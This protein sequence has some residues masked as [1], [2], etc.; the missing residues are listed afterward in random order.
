[1]NFV[2][3]AE[4]VLAQRSEL[5]LFPT[6]PGKV[7][8]IAVNSEGNDTSEAYLEI[9]DIEAPFHIWGINEDTKIAAGDNI[10]VICAASVYNYSSD[11]NWYLNNNLV[12]TGDNQIVEEY[13]TEYSYQK[14]ITWHGI[15]TIH[16]GTYECR[17]STVK[18]DTFSMETVHIQVHEPKKPEIESTNLKQDEIKLSL[19]E[20]FRMFC[21]IIA[22]P[23]PVISWYKNG[24]LIEN[25]TRISIS[26]DNQTLDIKYLKIEDDGEFKCVG[27]NRVGS[28]E[29][30][31]SLKI[32]NLPEVSLAWVI[33]IS[34]V[35][36]IL[37]ICT[38][39]LLIRF[40]RERRLRR[41]L[42]AA[43]LANFEEG[44][45]ESINP[46]LALDE[47]ADLLP[48]DKKYEFPREK[49]KLGK[50]LGA[51]AFGVVVK[52]LAHGILPYE[53]ETTVAVKMV[54]QTADNEV[55]RALV[56]ELK[57]MVHLGQ[58]LNVVN[59]LGA[60]TKNIAKREVM[61]IVE[62][63]R[64]GNVQNF[65][66]KHR[67]HY[68]DQINP[69]TDTIDPSILT[70]EQRYSNDSGYEY[71]SQGL[72]Y[73]KLSFSN[74][75]LN[76]S[77]RVPSHLNTGGGYIRQSDYFSGGMDSANT[78][79][80]LIRPVSGPGLTGEDNLMLSN[81]SVQPAWRSNYK[82]DYKGP[83]RVVTTT[84][85]V[86][87]SFQV[88]RGME[89]LA[90]RKV[91]HGDLAA[92]NILLCDDNVVKICD[93]G[94][95][96]SMYKSDNYK[97]KGEAPLPFKWLAIESIGD[98]VFSTYSDVW[99][100]GIVMW[101]LFSLGKVPYPGMDADQSLYMK[102]KDGYRMGKPE[103]ATQEIYDVMLHCWNANPE[104]R[105][106]FN[107]LEKRLGK[108]LESG[109]A[110]HYI[111]LNEPYLQINTDSF[112][113]GQ[114][115][116]LSFMGPPEGV[117]PSI[118]NYVNSSMK[119]SANAVPD[120][121]QVDSKSGSATYNTRDSGDKFETKTPVSPTIRNNLNHAS[122][123]SRSSKKPIP[124]EMPMLP[125][126]GTHRHSDSDV[127]SPD[128]KT[129]GK[130]FSGVSGS[131]ND[132]KGPDNYVNMPST[133]INMKDVYNNKD[134]VSNPGYVTFGKINETRT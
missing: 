46:E 47:Q 14:K 4:T 44:N 127:E 125:A 67:E 39:Y 10:T 89:Y 117:A 26:S 102:L 36:I 82:M 56:T 120:Y 7:E 9:T 20:P 80:A 41:E 2:T 15:K 122:P 60:V 115:D 79:V 84:D 68:I 75:H 100:F 63:C 110:E 6:E 3:T 42:K 105:P 71:N 50:Q 29:M 72:K 103:N 61:V 116:Y 134:A 99:S 21:N 8:C 34:V 106:L 38:I 109:V 58:H 28:V 88:A 18:D 17:A 76:N 104:S 87:W 83:M 65:L 94:L 70:K 1:G 12:E 130:D 69:E 97:K 113:Q 74:N 66:I 64:F 91:L 92:R 52:G 124:E 22:L 86:C 111:D 31:T 114:T 128:F 53:E 19:G 37:I 81:N 16:S 93:F 57:I 98:Q 55:M 5:N 129:A 119:P 33:G 131:K 23:D 30:F 73:V 101:E 48:Y 112:K 62:Y 35:I 118:P 40:Q 24:A 54:K 43:G 77:G 121:L 11:L 78:E 107:A 25:D 126:S 85:L 45:P 132:A 59:L 123:K 95:A 27:V 49:L 51:G 90:S 133:V 13:E 108:L 32:E 96:R